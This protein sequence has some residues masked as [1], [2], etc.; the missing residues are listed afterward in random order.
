M[1]RLTVLA[2]PLGANA[3]DVALRDWDGR[4]W[5]DSVAVLNETGRI[6]L[7]TFLDS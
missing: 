1:H 2:F 3:V 4:H 7:V 6:D 5:V